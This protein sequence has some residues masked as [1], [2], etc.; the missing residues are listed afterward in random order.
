MEA[1][2]FFSKIAGATFIM[3]DGHTIQFVHGIFDFDPENYKD[4][5]VNI[6]AMNG[7]IHAAHGKPKAEVYFQELQ[8]LVKT[9]N[10]LVFDPEHIAGVNAQLPAEIDPS[11]N[12]HSE[13]SILAAERLQATVTG[14]VTGDANNGI[15]NGQPTDVNA[16]TVDTNLQKQ[17]FK[18]ATGPGASAAVAAARARAAQQAATVQ[19]N[20][21]N[22]VAQ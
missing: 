21:K 10:P 1:K 8:H 16:S 22:N 5:V 4:E 19:A 7:Q 6:P 3:P 20:A 12:A 11:R 14:R 18:P 9:N 15:G 2:R 17:V 13:A